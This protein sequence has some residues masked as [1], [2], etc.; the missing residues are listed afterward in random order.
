MS[1]A[2][3]NVMDCG[4]DDVW[5]K[6]IWFRIKWFHNSQIIPW[7]SYPESKPMLR[8]FKATK[9][10]RLKLCWNRIFYEQTHTV[11]YWNQQRECDKKASYL[12]FFIMFY[13]CIFFFIR[14]HSL[15]TKKKH[16]SSL[17]W[18][19]LKLSNINASANYFY[20]LNHLL[21]F[22]LFYNLSQRILFLHLGGWGSAWMYSFNIMY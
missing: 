2:N 19:S 10:L 11:H 21:H 22:S 1:A 15:I 13:S 9:K 5:I 16:I 7:F 20:T 17:Q 6:Y 4:N 8:A 14:P 12:S 3:P 18:G